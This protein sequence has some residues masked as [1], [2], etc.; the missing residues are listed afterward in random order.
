MASGTA[1]TVSF[2]AV[3]YGIMMGPI[4]IGWGIIWLATAVVAIAWAIYPGNEPWTANQFVG[5]AFFVIC[6]PT[7]ALS[8]YKHNEKRG[9]TRPIKKAFFPLMILGLL[10]GATDGY[11]SKYANGYPVHEAGSPATYMIIVSFIAAA[12][13]TAYHVIL[14][15][16]L[17]YTPVVMKYAVLTGVTVLLQATGAAYGVKFL[18]V[19]RFL[20]I[21]ASSAIILSTAFSAYLYKEIPSATTLI[22]LAMSIGAIVF[23]ALG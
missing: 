22:G 12:G 20:P 6:L 14:R 8:T 18:Q 4:A 17:R 3:L 2:I 19:S 23:L 9:E 11:F 21:I 16:K 10:F 7:L 15:H 1:G 5:V 13:L